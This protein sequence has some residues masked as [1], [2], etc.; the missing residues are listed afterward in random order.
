MLYRTQRHTSALLLPAVLQLE[1]WYRLTNSCTLVVALHLVRGL[2][3][4]AQTGWNCLIAQFWR[5][6]SSMVD[7]PSALIC[8]ISVHSLYTVC[9]TVSFQPPF[10][11]GSM[12]T[13]YA[14]GSLY[15]YCYC[16]MH[17]TQLEEELSFIARC[18]HISSCMNIGGVDVSL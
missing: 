8:S 16:L 6:I 13:S 18:L 15:S 7:M 4:F 2:W 14:D 12:N 1:S 10:S 5:C 11:A 3:M 9:L 17:D